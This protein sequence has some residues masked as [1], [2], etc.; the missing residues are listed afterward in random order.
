MKV[1]TPSRPLDHLLRRKIFC[2]S[3]STLRPSDPAQPS[4]KRPRLDRNASTLSTTA[5]NGTRRVPQRNQPLYE[6]LTEIKAKAPGHINLSRLQLALQGL[7][8]EHPVTRIA[9][10]GLNVQDV[11]RQIARLLLVDA[12]ED[13]QGWEEQILQQQAAQGILIRYGQPQNASFP[14]RTTLPILHIPSPLLERLNIELLISSV[15]AEHS[16]TTIV[17]AETFLAPAVGVPTAF[18]GRQVTVN[19]PVHS[20][21]VVAQGFEELVTAIQLLSATGFQ[22]E[23]DKETVVLVANL[24]GSNSQSQDRVLLSD[25][26][27]AEKGL[28][29]IRRSTSEASIY[30]QEWVASGMPQIAKWLSEHSTT[31]QSS[32]TASPVVRRLISALLGAAELSVERSTLALQQQVRPGGLDM[33]V[34]TQIES[35]VEGFSRAAHQELQSGLASAWS[36]RNWRKLFWYKLFWRVDDVGLIISDLVTNTWLPKTERAVYEI[37]GRLT[38]IGISPVM[39]ESEVPEVQ[40]KTAFEPEPAKPTILDPAPPLLATATIA[41]SNELIAPP[42]EPVIA[43]VSPGQQPNVEMRPPALPVPITTTIST[44][45]SNYLSRQITILTTTA[46][47][48]VFRTLSISGLSAGLS[49]L[50]YV[51]TIAPTLY[52]AGSIF[53]A[54]TV[55]ALYR[56]QTGWQQATKTLEHGLF[57]EGR[58]VVRRTVQRM[59]ELVDI[60]AAEIV[61]GDPVEQQ[62]LADAQ[63]T[64]G[65][66][67]QAFKELQEQSRSAVS[68]GKR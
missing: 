44:S 65:K 14:Q 60:K 55:F 49:A 58:E 63:G 27:R 20:T 9:L 26:R 28:A 33:A 13:A 8:S 40:Q 6:A 39:A 37:S 52:E 41:P 3:C 62:M 21:L 66:A 11:A 53:A 35:A 30:S 48:L 5:I 47:Q 36:S 68:E 45:R 54:G 57:E 31:E 16:N 15:N 32:Q 34:R 59:R 56:M 64:V 25:V 12:L 19:Q 1:C 51:S 7:E 67:R 29:A 4:R 22:T 43:A 17:P 38:Q 10:L 50:T 24:P 18:D 46:Q 42:L 23:A 61:P 2:P